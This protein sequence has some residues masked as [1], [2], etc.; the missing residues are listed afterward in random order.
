MQH[1]LVQINFDKE[2][3]GIVLGSVVCEP[4]VVFKEVASAAAVCRSPI[5]LVLTQVRLA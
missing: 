5:L 3:D 4:P 2:A 1:D